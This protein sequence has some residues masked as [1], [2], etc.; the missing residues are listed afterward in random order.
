LIPK[1]VALVAGFL[2]SLSSPVWSQR[3]L[4]WR[5][6]DVTAT[7]DR[8]G[9][10][11]VRE[12][13]A[14]VFTGDWNGGER[15]FRIRWDQKLELES[16]TREDPPSPLR[17][18]LSEEDIENIAAGGTDSLDKY[19]WADATTLRWR[20][21]LP[22]DPE[23]D[24]REI[25]YTLDYTLSNIL[26]PQDDGTFLLD[27][28][29]ALPDREWPILE[30]TLD[31]S[32][33]P[34]WSG[35]QESS[36]RF[37][38]KDLPPGAD[39]V[40]TVPL[41]FQGEGAPS[42]VRLPAGRFT[43]SALAL[44]FLGGLATIGI[45]FYRS[46]NALGRFAPLA[47]RDSIDESWLREHVFSMLPEEVG[48]AWD[49]T[50]S[51][52]EVAAVLARMVSEKKLASDVY[53]TKGFLHSSENLRLRLLVPRGNLKGYER[54]LVD[55]LFVSGE[56]TDTEKIRA[57]YRSRGFDPAS[58]IESHLKRR[59]KSLLGS[60]G[61]RTISKK[62]A[63]YLLLAS[64]L[65]FAIAVREFPRIV[66]P[67]VAGSILYCIAAIP[68]GFYRRRVE[69]LFSFA[70]SFLVPAAL[71]AASASYFL[72]FNTQRGAFALAGIGLFYLALLVSVFNKAKFR[73]GVTALALRKTLAAARRFFATELAK[74]SPRLKDEWFPYLLAFELGPDV[75]RWFRAYGPAG[76]STTS[77]FGS[78][79]TSSSTGSTGSG[80]GP[81][82]G[83]GGAFGGAGATASW[84]T[85]V[86]SV[87]S[88]VAAPSS[89]GSSGGGSG[90]GGGGGGGGSSG[91]GGGGGW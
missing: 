79:G 21:R 25:V 62:P 59:V 4:H 89:S 84:A 64:I 36:M 18:A 47:P 65:C 80:S 58:K 83:G 31:L 6:L 22:S 63:L 56:V 23:F 86:G 52:P 76:S 7:L 1:R 85:A 9:R 46:E 57:H 61:T 91:G 73:D 54:T 35:P 55:A 11:H 38:R 50:T 24:S 14:M 88:G 37:A 2:L 77:D 66:F 34:I 44:A 68:A 5:S 78:A 12:R 49:D 81:F 17:I 40:V 43:R 70:L 8:E 33:D 26:I 87:A 69:R 71:L 42:G 60:G 20:S 28:N 53:Q 10:L 74:K 15:R 27:H 41:A 19:G 45:A 48:A 16:V 30:F 67:V 32:L 75:S 51:S 82:T 72:F 13:H 29:F 90:G 39:F 3:Q